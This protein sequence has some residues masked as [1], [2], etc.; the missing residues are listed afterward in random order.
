ML[1]FRRLLCALVLVGILGGAVSSVSADS[2]QHTQNGEASMV[3][4]Q[5]CASTDGVSS[6]ACDSDCYR[7]SSSDAM[8]C[9]P[10]EGTHGCVAVLARA[11][12]VGSLEISR[13]G[14]AGVLQQAGG[15]LLT[16][17]FGPPRA[18]S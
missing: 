16:P 11:P 3:S 9:G 18:F 5:G 1:L 10:C 7:P 15:L 4:D 2:W 14:T 8:D 13:A 6:V 12:L 17:P